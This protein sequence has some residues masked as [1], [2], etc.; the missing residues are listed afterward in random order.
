WSL[1]DAPSPDDAARLLDDL[2]ALRAA[3]LR[4]PL[5]LPPE[6][7][8]AYAVSRGGGTGDPGQALGEARY[9]WNGGFEKS[10]PYHVLCW[11]DGARLDDFAGVPD[12]DDR[13][14]AGDEPTRL[15]A[16]ARRVW[17]PLLSHE[18]KGTS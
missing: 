5:P 3:A 7:A 6:A 11:G 13:R 18:Q 10:D 9:T 12:D 8:H 14:A 16:L 15:G 1:L 2:V 17:D 4:G